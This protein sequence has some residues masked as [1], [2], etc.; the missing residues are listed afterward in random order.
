MT[1]LL[2]A[3]LPL[4]IA[5]LL[6]LG[7]FSYRKKS[8]LSRLSQPPPVPTNRVNLHPDP[9]PEEV[10]N[11]M[12]K[13][14]WRPLPR[15]ALLHYQKARASEVEAHR[16]ESVE[17]PANPERELAPSPRLVARPGAAQPGPARPVDPATL[18]PPT[19]PWLDDADAATKVSRRRKGLESL[20][21][22]KS[23]SPRE[24]SQ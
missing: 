11:P 23:P 4:T 17:A 7:R 8:R 24:N 20:I 1:Y 6:G 16:R 18:V 3:F 15:K 14:A 5:T 2:M 13:M 9:Q 12:E 21:N 10:T 22:L 19:I